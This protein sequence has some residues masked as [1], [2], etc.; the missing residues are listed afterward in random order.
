MKKLF[1]KIMDA[2][3][4]HQNEKCQKCP[5]GWSDG[6]YSECG[7]YLEEGRLGEGIRKLQQKLGDGGFGGCLIPLPIIKLYVECTWGRQQR[8]YE[9]RARQELAKQ[10]ESLE[11]E[12]V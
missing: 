2:F 11:D 10:M 9:K 6:M 4:D 12:E 3:E 1:S 7:C 8:K 5:C